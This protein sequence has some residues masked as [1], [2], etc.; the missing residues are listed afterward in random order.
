MKP[1]GTVSGVAVPIEGENV[2]TD[3]ILPARF[4]PKPRNGGFGQYLFH[5]IRFDD[6]GTEKPDFI[7]NRPAFRGASVLIGEANFGCGSSRENAV[8]AIADYGIRAVIAPSFGDI[9]YSNNIKNGVLPVVLTKDDVARLIEDQLHEPGQ[10]VTVNL[11]EQTVTAGNRVYHF[12]IDEFSRHCLLHGID[13]LDYTLSQL[14]A[15]DAFAARRA[16]EEGWPAQAPRTASASDDG[17][18]I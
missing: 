10:P 17:A 12:K 11:Q 5:D 18:N 8:W 15:I 14:D 2:D 16:A 9:F 4:L 13:E 3:Q 7:L 6:S 1:F